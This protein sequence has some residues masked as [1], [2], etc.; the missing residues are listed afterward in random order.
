LL[1]R[2]L[3]DD[4]TRWREN[5]AGE[6][7]KFFFVTSSAYIGVAREKSEAVRDGINETVGNIEAAAFGGNVIQISLRS[8]TAWEVRMCPIARSLL[9]GG[10]AGTSAPFHLFGKLHAWIP[11]NDMSFATRKR[12]FPLR[13]PPQDFQPS[14]LAFSHR[15]N[16]SAPRL[17]HGE[18]GPF[19][20]AWRT[21]AFWSG[22]NV[23]PYLKVR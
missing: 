20:I 10:K 15:D 5:S 11:A 7:A 16:A 9:L 2:S 22:V 21:I 4:V 19:S 14:P 23:L 12:G 17:P 6:G 8:G 18:T 1:G 13:Q 3:H